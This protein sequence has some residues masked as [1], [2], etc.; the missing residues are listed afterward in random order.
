MVQS[1]PDDEKHLEQREKHYKSQ[2][3]KTNVLIGLTIS[4]IVISI[5][6]IFFSDDQGDA[7]QQ[8]LNKLMGIA[9]EGQKQEFESLK[10]IKDTIKQS[11]EIKS[12]ISLKII[13]QGLSYDSFEA[14]N[15]FQSSSEGTTHEVIITEKP[16]TLREDDDI[17]FNLLVTNVGSDTIYLNSHSLAY[18]IVDTDDTGGTTL[19]RTNVHPNGTVLSHNIGDFLEPNSYKIIPFWLEIDSIF[20]PNGRII[21]TVFY[22][23]GKHETASINYVFES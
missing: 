6:S 2:N 1:I 22:E 11:A 12:L 17:Q 5:V 14:V 10:S 8:S 18:V 3:R 4:L 23:N 16:I 21:F 19:F 20:T 7:L 13:P 9:E 15:R